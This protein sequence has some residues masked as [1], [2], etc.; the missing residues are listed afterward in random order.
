MSTAIPKA[1]IHRTLCPM[2]KAVTAFLIHKSCSQ[3]NSAWL[4]CQACDTGFEHGEVHRDKRLQ[5][6][7]LMRDLKL[8]IAGGEIQETSEYLQPR[9]WGIR[10]L[11]DGSHR[12][13]MEESEARDWASRFPDK[14]TLITRGPWE[15]SQ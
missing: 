4:Q 8:R 5:F 11:V 13:G 6:Q 2:C 1:T 15:D 7:S 12:L 3:W 10:S 9:E 14:Y